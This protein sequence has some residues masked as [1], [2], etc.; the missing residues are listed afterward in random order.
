MVKEV[1]VVDDDDMEVDFSSV[2]MPMMML[3]M[4]IALM[5]VM[6]DV[7]TSSAQAAAVAQGTLALGLNE[8]YDVTAKTT[9]QEVEFSQPMQSLMVT[10]DG[11]TIVYIKLNSLSAKP[12]EVRGGETLE[13]SYNTHV[14]ERVFYYTISGQSGLRIT[15][16]G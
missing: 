16:T 5:S 12:N 3:I 15:G 9:V 4:M 2:M 8:P 13:L 14:I 10:N 6:T 11:A 1:T 7:S